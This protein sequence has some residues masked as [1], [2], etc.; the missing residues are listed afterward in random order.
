[1][2]APLGS[3]DRPDSYIGRS[4]SRPN[5]KR[6]L[7]GRGRYVTDL[8]LPRMLH[9][10]FFRSPYA[11][12]RIVSI[13]AAEALVMPGV[14]LVATGEDLARICTLRIGTLDR[15]KGMKSPPQLPSAA[16]R[17]PIRDRE[18]RDDNPPHLR[19]AHPGI[20]K[21][22]AYA[23]LPQVRRSRSDG[24][25]RRPFGRIR[26]VARPV[27]IQTKDRRE[28]RWRSGGIFQWCGPL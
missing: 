11:H 25:A 6:L 1:M 9:A 26:L 5:A 27:V 22:S 10:A 4:V 17:R 16:C 2:N 28:G 14:R 18:R 12:A 20:K 21:L 3:P 15:F 8:S 23:E 13:N 7:A 19:H 24:V